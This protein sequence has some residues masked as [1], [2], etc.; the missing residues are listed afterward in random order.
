ML[1]YSS[2]L[3]FII[4]LYDVRREV[5]L[6]IIIVFLLCGWRDILA[7]ISRTLRETARNYGIILVVK[8]K[9]DI[10]QT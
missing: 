10:I 9:L 5:G 6:T 1:C 3:Q 2:F 8:F 7:R 4:V